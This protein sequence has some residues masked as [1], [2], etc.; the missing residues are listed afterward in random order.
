[1]KHSISAL[2]LLLT[3][4][5]HC[6]AEEVAKDTFWLTDHAK[7]FAKA[8][9]EKKL[10]LLEFYG[11][12]WCPS[13][14]VLEAKVLAKSEFQEA[15]RKKFIPLRLDFPIRSKQPDELKEAN[16]ALVVKYNAEL[17]PTLLIID[18]E[19][20]E[21]GRKEGYSGESISDYMTFLEESLANSR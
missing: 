11:S 18:A 16:E 6:V 2:I 7:A 8:R 1:M 20:D 13:C 9:E 10:L 12:D 5:L 14:K 19:G 21:K 15:V 3:I 17:F 4:S